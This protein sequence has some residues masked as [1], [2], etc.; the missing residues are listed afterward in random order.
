MKI[1][2]WAGYG[3]VN[4]RKV[5]DGSCTLHIRVEGNHEQGVMLCNWQTYEL[6]NWLVRRF[7]KKVQ[8][9]SMWIHS[10]PIIDI[11]P[12]FRTDPVLGVIDTCD[13]Y[14]TY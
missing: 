11:R 5:N 7:D 3:C 1:K 6:Y 4:A 13:Y 2:H 9:A 12:G 14:F 10:R 8:D